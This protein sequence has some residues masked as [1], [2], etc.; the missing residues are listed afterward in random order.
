MQFVTQAMLQRFAKAQPVDGA[1][2]MLV[3]LGGGGLPASETAFAE[4]FDD[5]A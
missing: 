1:R 3:D 4:A 2:A 5:L